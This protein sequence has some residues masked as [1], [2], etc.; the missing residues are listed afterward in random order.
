MD[1]RKIYIH[2]YIDEFLNRPRVRINFR[3]KC[4]ESRD[5]DSRAGRY[6]EIRNRGIIK[7]RVVSVSE[8][9]WFSSYLFS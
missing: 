4:L 5:L 7:T 9:E 6:R 8:R 1:V 3:K 2:I